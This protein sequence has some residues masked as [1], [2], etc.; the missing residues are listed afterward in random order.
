MKSKLHLNWKEICILEDIFQKCVR[1]LPIN[2]ELVS[3]ESIKGILTLCKDLFR[4]LSNI[5]VGAYC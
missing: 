4:I 5:K 1:H 3:E 2:M